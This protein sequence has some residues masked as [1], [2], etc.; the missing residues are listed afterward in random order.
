MAGR[1]RK[2]RGTDPAGKTNT[3]PDKQPDDR[4][5][6]ARQPHR[7]ALEDNL[8]TR[9]EAESPIGRLL[10]AGKLNRADD[11]H[12]GVARHRYHAA[13]LFAGVVGAYRS[14]IEAPK[15][16][17]GSGRGFPCEPSL[18]AAN[19]A[20]EEL[21]Q[22]LARRRRYQRAYEALADD[23]RVEFWAKPKDPLREAELAHLKL[24]EDEQFRKALR[25]KRRALMAVIRVAIHREPIADGDLVFLTIGLDKLV[26]HFGLGARRS[27]ERAT[28]APARD[29]APPSA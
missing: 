12:P 24:R 21:C 7:R 17:A 6:T 3:K 9:E 25:D 4:V 27:R 16:V 22:C 18:C 14:V 29:A 10:L 11:H 26:R 2:F 20:D 23:A 15:D 5:R 13:E 28:I 19:I 1:K 8:R